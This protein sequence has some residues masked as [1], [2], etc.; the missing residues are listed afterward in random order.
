MIGIYHVLALGKVFY[1]VRACD[2][3][4][5][6]YHVRALEKVISHVLV[7]VLDNG[8]ERFFWSLSYGDVV[9]AMVIYHV[10]ALGKVIYPISDV[11]LFSGILHLS[12][13][14]L[15]LVVHRP[16]FYTSSYATVAG[17]QNQYHRQSHVFYLLL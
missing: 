8:R 17:D 12:T 2:L 15:L 7:C 10:R 6:I 1:H 16:F 9:Q 13:L 11:F 5:G 4:I 3:V 14:F